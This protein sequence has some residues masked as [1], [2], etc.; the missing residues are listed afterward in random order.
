V[1]GASGCD[2]NVTRCHPHRRTGGIEL[3]FTNARDHGPRVLT[4]GMRVR[5]EALS[6]FEG[7]GDHNL[8]SEPAG[9]TACW[10]SWADSEKRG[11]LM[12]Q[13]ALQAESLKADTASARFWA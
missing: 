9:A 11:A 8:N 4:V 3:V 10:L 12:R 1:H 6:R 2:R 7:P 5:A 13:E